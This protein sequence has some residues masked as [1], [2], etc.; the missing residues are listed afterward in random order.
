MGVI[1]V[2]EDVEDIGGI[3]SLGQR[4]EIANRPGDPAAEHEPLPGKQEGILHGSL[5][6][7]LVAA[8]FKLREIVKLENEFIVICA[9]LEARAEPEVALE[10]LERSGLVEAVRGGRIWG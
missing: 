8:I 10:A 2:E 1:E 7:L 9:E 3:K 6:V 4:D 5:T